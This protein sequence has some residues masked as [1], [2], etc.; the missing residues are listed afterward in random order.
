MTIY[1]LSTG[2]GI[3][4]VA[5][6]RISGPEDALAQFS[7]VK[8]DVLRAGIVDEAAVAVYDAPAPDKELLAVEVDLAAVNPN[9]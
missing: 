2:P 1:A 9:A 5:V 8:G 3:S 6:I 4:G 7:L